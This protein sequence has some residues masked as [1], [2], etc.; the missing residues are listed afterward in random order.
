MVAR[1]E[2][3]VVHENGS[4]RRHFDYAPRI[5]LATFSAAKTT[6]HL[7]VSREITYVWAAPFTAKRDEWRF[8]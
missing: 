8:Q 2:L 5:H 1:P 4:R 7:I 6:A 3:G